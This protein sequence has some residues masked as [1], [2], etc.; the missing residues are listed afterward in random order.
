MSTFFHLSNIIR[1]CVAIEM[2]AE[3][4]NNL[5]YLLELGLLHLFYPPGFFWFTT[6]YIYK[7]MLK[8]QTLLPEVAHT[9]KS[10]K[11]IGTR[12]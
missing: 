10:H 7:F 3:L 2:W 12:T 9:H 5:I 4:K 1:L 8:A 11:P 6:L